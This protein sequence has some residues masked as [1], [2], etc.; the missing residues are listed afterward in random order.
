MYDGHQNA[1]KEVGGIGGAFK[2]ATPRQEVAVLA[3]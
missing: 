2:S 3:R 1:K